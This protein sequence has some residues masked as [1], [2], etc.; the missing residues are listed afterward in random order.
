MLFC[1][2]ISVSWLLIGV[3]DVGHTRKDDGDTIVVEAVR[4]ASW[5]RPRGMV[6]SCDNKT[7]IDIHYVR[8]YKKIADANEWPQFFVLYMDGNLRLI[9]HPPVGVPSVCFGSSVIIGSASVASRPLA[10]IA[11]VRYLKPSNTL[12][13]VYQTGGSALLSLQDVDRT[14]ARVGISVNYPTDTAPFATFR[15]MFVTDG[16][17]DTDH[18]L[19]TAASGSAHDDA[20]LTFSGG[21]GTEWFFYLRTPS[22]HNTSAPDILVWVE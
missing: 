7:E 9:P 6:A 1:Q 17:A 4:E 14:R 3:A 11:S 21:G 12:E 20:I 15:S 13:V 22:Q 18:V 8:V 10:E 5:W 16:N 2:V 19:W